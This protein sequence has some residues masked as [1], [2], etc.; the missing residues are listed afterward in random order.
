MIFL[1]FHGGETVPV[2]PP[3][4]RWTGPVNAMTDEPRRVLI[5][6]AD[7]DDRAA[8]QR[9]LSADSAR[10]YAFGEAG[11]GAAGLRACRAAGDG[12]PHCILLDA[13][14]PDGGAL[15]FLAELGGRKGIPWPVVAVTG[16]AGGPGDGA[17]LLRAGVQE[18]VGRGWLNAESL[19]QA[20]ERAIERHALARDQG[21]CQERLRTAAE[22]KSRYQNSL[23]EG[24]N[25]IFREALACETEGQLGAL[26]LAVAE[27]VTGSRFGFVGEINARTGL[28]DGIAISDPG[29]EACRIPHPPGHGRKVPA[30]FRIHG[31]YG[32]VLRDGRGLFTNDPAAHP[33]RIGVPEGHPPLEA[34]LGVPLKQ[35]GQ[36]IGLVAVG[37]REGGYRAEDLAAL[38]ALAPP[39]VQVLMRRRAEAALRDSEERLRLA[40]E[41]ARMATWDWRPAE[42]TLV[43][44]DEHYRLLGYEPG[45]VPASYRV[46]LERVHPEDRVATEARL[47]QSMN[48]GGDYQ[49]E[50]RTVAPDGTLRWVEARGRFERDAAG[51]AVRSYG[52]AL[53]ITRRKQAE[54]A[55]RNMALFPA[56]NPSPVLRVGRDD[57]LLYANRASE[58]LLAH[59]GCRIGQAVPPAVAEAVQAAWNEAALREWEVGIDGRT[60]LF[61]ISPMAELGYA[62][63]YGRDIT[64][65]KRAEEALRESEARFRTLANAA[66]VLIWIAGADRLCTWFNQQWLD[67]TGRALAQE[68]GCGWAE[69][70]H[71]EDRERCLAVYT[72]HFDRREPFDLEYRL[73]RA[74]GAYRWVLDRGVP[75]FGV[76]G[77]FL[78]YI[79]SCTDITGRKQAETDLEAARAEA[80]TERNR[81]EAVMQAL[82]VGMALVDERGGRIR[83]N[84]AY[85]QVWA[86]PCPPARSIG[87]YAAYRAWWADTGQMV[88][89]EEWASARAVL[90]GET[91]IGQLLEIQRF[92]GTRAF[93]LNS[94]APMRAADGRIVG[95]AVAIQDITAL[96]EAETALRHSE[97]RFR[98]LSD[99]AGRLLAAEDPQTL[100]NGLCR[101]IMAHL[102]CQVFFNFLVDEP[103]GRLRLN[104]CAG[105]PEEEVR[106]I[107]WLDYGVAVCGCVARE[108]RRI[109]A[110]DIRHTPDP[111]TELVRGYGIQAYCCHPLLA[112]GR[113]IGTL[114]FGTR[115]RER[116]AVGDVELMRTVADHVAVA[117]ERLQAR[118]ALRDSESFHR[119]VLESI[120]G[121]VFTTRPDGYCD[122]QSQQ[123]VDYTGIPTSE[124]LGDGWNRLLHPDDRAPALAAWQAAVEGRAPYDLE[125]RVRRRDGEYEWFKVRGRPI[126]DEEG[127]IVR[128]FGAAV[129]IE[130]MKRAE[131]ALRASEERYRSLV[132][133]TVD[134]IF[135]SDSGGRYLDVNSAGAAMLGYTRAEILKLGIPDVIA[136]E[137]TPR[138]APEVAKLAGGE[139]VRSEWRF[140]RRDGS[141]F[142][143]EVMARRLSDGRLQAIL[144]DI[145]ERK[146]VEATLREQADRLREADRRKDEF[147]AMLAH[148][149]RNP[150]APIRNAVY[151]LRRPYLSEAQLS[152]CHEVIG[153]QTEQL[154][155]LVDDLLDVSRIT[156]GKIELQK[157]TLD[158]AEVAQRAVET[159]RPLI[160]AHRHELGV[161]LPREPVRVEGDRVRLAQVVSNLL[162]N[163]AKYTDEGGTIRVAVERAGGE[164]LIRVRDTG[165]GIDPKLLPD[166]FDLF[167]QVDRTLDRS[168]GGLGIGLSLVKRLVELHGG[169]VEA[170]SEGWGRG[171]EFTI[172]LPAILDG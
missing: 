12:P 164:A 37:N 87:D 115:T 166:V 109:L 92:D 56:Q 124:Q 20:V 127:R 25:R 88:Q 148:E 139:V 13:G 118:Q 38:E 60:L 152:W 70:V 27:D 4:V 77:E 52:V 1:P 17:A 155:R 91:V 110:E 24:I 112:Q 116:F 61:Q 103:A 10:H 23:L 111:R 73:R 39:I 144:R 160:D 30:A 98:L 120:P 114:S 59:W 8:W 167:Y 66:P 113:V 131:A 31:L 153:R 43:W 62:N 58:P 45:S 6:G 150:L 158:L 19:G 128:W 76:G 57:R 72:G 129:N 26:C 11:T 3:P 123:W 145:T 105:I 14:L 107:G 161:C 156:R 78:G 142:P 96:K 154:T 140:R 75:R 68:L 135:V 119:Q 53:D 33:D 146:Q 9:L 82:P 16:L 21:A 90:H 133:Q 89:P 97:A 7:L 157:E 79:G 41:A 108:G 15:A 138:I 93:V 130:G 69:S 106:R 99:V 147:L 63:L 80:V 165:R 35:D 134:G 74:D 84:A 50:Y 48:R 137:E 64:E 143:G 95:S 51:R 149:L 67:F 44:N 42:G 172:R 170:F 117:M 28:L 136:P 55:I 18:V 162:N 5:V 125:Y 71:P 86:G 163:A 132:E 46:W 104:A 100:V 168:E 151:I 65:H 102:D 2:S 40:L 81:L 85:E 171:S 141:G 126:R 54:E 121:M 159:S 47:R 34:F 32:R 122:Y 94:A 36:T 22:E 49:A 101:D 29:W 169:R 83:A